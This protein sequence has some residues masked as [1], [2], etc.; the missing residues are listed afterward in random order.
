[1]NRGVKQ[2]GKQSENEVVAIVE[3][4]AGSLT[5]R[6]NP[7]RSII[8]AAKRAKEKLLSERESD[9]EEIEALE[10]KHAAEMEAVKQ[11]RADR[12]NRQLREAMDL[13]NAAVNGPLEEE[14]KGLVAT[15]G[16]RCAALSAV[17]DGLI[18][19]YLKSHKITDDQ[20][21]EAL[22]ITPTAI[23]VFLQKGSS[24]DGETGARV[25]NLA[26]QVQA[27]QE[28]VEALASRSR[29]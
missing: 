17:L 13:E 10:A 12:I 23:K 24:S 28:Q 21:K 3:Q 14:Y 9:R 22:S 5:T 18:D 29:R 1:M 7:V 20:A 2:M 11:R 6:S 8:D 4:K 27:L 16:R 25:L 19:G 15:V 26:A